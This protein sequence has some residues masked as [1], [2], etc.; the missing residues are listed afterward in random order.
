[1]LLDL[2]LI[3]I[4]YANQNEFVSSPFTNLCLCFDILSFFITGKFHVFS[5]ICFKHFYLWQKEDCYDVY[6][7]VDYI[8]G[9]LVNTVSKKKKKLE[10]QQTYFSQRSNSSS[11]FFLIRLLFFILS[12]SLTFFTNKKKKNDRKSSFHTVSTTLLYANLS[13]FIY[14][15]Q[16]KRMHRISSRIECQVQWHYHATQTAYIL[17]PIY[18]IELCTRLK[19]LHLHSALISVYTHSQHIS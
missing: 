8:N 6:N 3:W 11:S 17:S 10:L 12:A 5:Q 1:M 14:Q 13:A 19:H 9:K 4:L 18:S 16:C 15:F 7:R 2:H